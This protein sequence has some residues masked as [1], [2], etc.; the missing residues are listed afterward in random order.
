MG[1]KAVFIDRDGT[2]A[3]DAHYCSKPEDLKL[4]PN[5]T[6]GLKLLKQHGYTL[7]V[8]TNQSGI[9]RGIF[10]EETLN[11]IHDKMKKDLAADGASV[12]GI[13][14]CPHHPDQK[15]DCRKPKPKM[16]LQA[17]REHD[18]DLSRSFI[19]GDL[20]MDIDLGKSTG[21]PVIWIDHGT[22]T[23]EAPPDAIASDLLEAAE[24][25]L[26]WDSISS[27]NKEGKK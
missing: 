8:I 21:C 18:I 10:T 6:E 9:G 11:V 4:Y 5:T 23:Y 25:I 15:C 22:M 27:S 2:M 14:Y 13:Y 24:L 12:D 17:V 20:Q 26:N 16:V 3:V 19:V 7:I 1:N